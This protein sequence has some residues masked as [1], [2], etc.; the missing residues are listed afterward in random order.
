MLSRSPSSSS[1]RIKLEVSLSPTNN[2][3]EGVE[4]SQPEEPDQGD[5][6]NSCSICLHS[7]ADRTVIPKC[8][9]EFCFEC[10]LVW[11]GMYSHS[12]PVIFIAGMNYLSVEQSRRCPLCSQAIG[13]YLIHSIRSR[14]DYRK[15]YLTPLRKSPPPS[16]PAQTNTVLQNTRQR[17]RRER[18]WGVRARESDEADKLERSIAKRRWIYRHDLYSKV[19]FEFSS[20]SLLTLI[21]LYDFCKACCIQFLHKISPISYTCPICCI[22]RSYI[23]YHNISTKRTTDLGRFRCRGEIST[24][25]LCTFL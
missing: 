9:H 1:K 5:S 16:R 24:Y 7:I 15:H 8:S 20:L 22:P 12:S 2:V 14:Y 18:E 21:I 4:I 11:T 19:Y 3:L 25:P 17:R 13:E 10:L 23:T 6:E